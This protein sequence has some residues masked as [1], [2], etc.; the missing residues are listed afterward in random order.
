MS[1]L[2][3]EM[4]PAFFSEVSEQL[5][6]LEVILSSVSASNFDVGQ[7]FRL[8]HT[9]KSSTAMMDFK[10]MELLAHAAEDILDL[11]RSGD[12]AMSESI[13][14]VLVAVAGQ[15]KTQWQEADKTRVS[16]AGE[17]ATSRPSARNAGGGRR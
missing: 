1:S 9:I 3:D 17:P 7:T 14:D 8:F 16:P 15:L 2:F 6:E 4:W 11:I 5:D 10:D 12:A 13:C